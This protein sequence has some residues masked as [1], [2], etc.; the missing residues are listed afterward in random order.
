[1][2][3]TRKLKLEIELENDAVRNVNSVAALLGVVA[4]DVRSKAPTDLGACLP[5]KIRDINGNTVGSWQIVEEE[6][7]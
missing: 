7:A 4:K 1:M 6:D 3:Q 2:S 5:K